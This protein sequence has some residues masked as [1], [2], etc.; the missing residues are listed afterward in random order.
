MRSKAK[1]ISS[2]QFKDLVYQNLARF[3]GALS[4]PVR[5]ELLDLLCQSERTGEVLAAL[6][7]SSVANVSH[8]LQTLKGAGLVES[9]RAGKYIF[10]S[11][12]SSGMKCWASLAQTG[13]ESLPELRLAVHD[14]FF[15]IETS[16]EISILE[17]S[18]KAR[19]GEI[20]VIDV[21]PQEEYDTWHVPGALNLPMEELDA[22]L[23][24]L[25]SGKRIMAYC[26]GPYCVLS[27]EAVERLRAKG[28]QACRVA[29]DLVAQRS[30]L[31]HSE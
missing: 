16:E 17:L 14:F 10:Y 27:R 6:T 2:R 20:I 15:D 9:R 26:R 4:A 19:K 25:P 22:K 5:L 24:S 18:K 8:H 1:R 11:A 12:T 30:S 31:E 23:T 29:L 28:F 21:R 3:A 7:N 13:E